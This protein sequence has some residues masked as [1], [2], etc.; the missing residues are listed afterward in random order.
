MDFDNGLTFEQ[1]QNTSETALD[2]YVGYDYI[3]ANTGTLEEYRDKV[4]NIIKT[5]LG[6]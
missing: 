5:E 4:R 2:D 6:L 3:I 1:K